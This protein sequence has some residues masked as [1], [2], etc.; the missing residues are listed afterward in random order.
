MVQ[1]RGDPPS[2]DGDLKQWTNRRGQAITY[3][4]DAVHRLTQKAGTNTDTLTWTYGA[5][6]TRKV[7]A[8]SAVSSDTVYY[9]VLGTPDLLKTVMANQTF[10]R[11]Y[12][13]RVT[14]QPLADTVSGGGITSWQVRQ[15]TYEQATALLASIK[16]GGRTTTIRADSNMDGRA[17]TLP[18]G[19]VDTN[20]LGN[21]RVPLDL[22]TNAPYASTTDRLL[23]LDNGYRLQQHF[24]NV[25]P[26]AGRFFAYDSLGE[27]TSASDKHWT[28]ALPGNCLNTV[29]GYNCQASGSGWTTDNSASFSYDAAGNRTSQGGTYGSANRITGFNGCTYGTDADG[30]V[31]SR[32][33]TG[34]PSLT[35]TFTWSA[36]G[37]LKSITNQGNTYN[38][39]YNA[40]GQLV[41][42]DLGATPQAHYLWDG[43]NLLAELNG[44]ATIKLA[45]YSYYPGLD[46]LHALIQGAALYMAHEDGVGNVIALT[47]STK[48]L[49]RTYT[50][51]DWGLLTGGTDTHNFAG[52]DR[53]RWKG[54]IATTLAGGDLYYMRNRWYEPQTGR[55]LS[56]DPIGVA[57][58]LNYYTFGGNDPID[59]SDP[60]GL[61]TV[62]VIDEVTQEQTCEDPGQDPQ[63]LPEVVSW[64]SDLDRAGC[65][66]GPRLSSADW[67]A[68]SS[69]GVR[70]VGFDGLPPWQSNGLR[71]K[72][73][74]GAAKAKQWASNLSNSECRFNTGMAALSIAG[75]IS[76]ALVAAK[77][78]TYG[79][80]GAR[81]LAFAASSTGK[82]SDAYITG[83]LRRF[84]ASRFMTKVGATGYGSGLTSSA[85]GAVGSGSDISWKDFVPIWGSV[86]AVQAA[87][88]ACLGS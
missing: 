1:N 45:E 75:D 56:E 63:E 76:L 57:G 60:S 49:Q 48:A 44:P 34:Q 50:Y 31:T 39:Q 19:E 59:A 35:A 71:D 8:R 66:M 81:L 82:A 37:R 52:V 65:W 24:K 28:A 86:R 88:N 27:L 62:W 20:T 53:A 42:I 25:T 87:Q 64:G 72:F 43:D 6:A 47:D 55:F 80:R 77:A 51:D 32:T 14:G 4:Y 58:G 23:S 36:E 21:L 10:T 79:I 22:K 54:A 11:H 83:A 9:N 13:Y 40:S 3:T 30:N 18:G 15:Y 16:I 7:T 33:C 5:T 68:C 78:V 67:G 38:L 26:A 29:F 69:W 70:M 74:A 46:N 41:R 12:L 84:D 61:C 17:V 85:Y 2:L 73:R